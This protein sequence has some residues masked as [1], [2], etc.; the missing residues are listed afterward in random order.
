[1]HPG[2]TLQQDLQLRFLAPQIPTILYGKYFAGKKM[3]GSVDKQFIGMI[4]GP[5][6]C[7]MSAAIC[8]C[9]RAWQTGTYVEPKDFK[10]E[11]SL[12]MLAAKIRNVDTNKRNRFI[13]APD[14]DMA[15]HTIELAGDDFKRSS[16]RNPGPY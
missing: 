10:R 1:M 3:R 2:L 9:L 15:K 6:L 4:N 7:L 14:R 8:H 16:H 5:L 13:E 12:G 11:T